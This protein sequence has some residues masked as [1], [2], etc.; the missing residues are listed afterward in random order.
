MSQTYN[1]TNDCFV[2]T[3]DVQT[4]MA[5]IENNLMALKNTFHGSTAP[6]NPLKLVAFQV[7][8]CQY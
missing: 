8:M 4:N 2:A 7:V 1:F 5:A 6:S 3:E